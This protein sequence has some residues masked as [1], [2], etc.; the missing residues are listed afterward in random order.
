MSSNIYISMEIRQLQYRYA[1]E[2]S[3]FK[4]REEINIDGNS[5]ALCKFCH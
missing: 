3:L 5:N 4:I 1:F 2:N